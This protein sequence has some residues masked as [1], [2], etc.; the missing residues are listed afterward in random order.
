MHDFTL[1]RICCKKR[2]ETCHS[3]NI[4]IIVK[5]IRTDLLRKACWITILPFLKTKYLQIKRTPYYFSNSIKRSFFFFRHGRS[6][7][8]VHNSYG[9]FF[10]GISG[11]KFR[12]PKN[13]QKSL[14]NDKN[15]QIFSVKYGI[16][17]NLYGIQAKIDQFRWIV[18]VFQWFLPI[19]WL[20]EFW[21]R[22]SVKKNSVRIMTIWARSSVPIFFAQ[23]SNQ[24][25]H[26]KIKPS[27]SLDRGDRRTFGFVC[28]KFP[29]GYFD[30][31]F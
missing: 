16:R 13:W 31:R 7:P 17:S 22:N 11:P 10:Y 12:K 25:I 26:R 5:T 18:V 9:I 8:N 27:L 4:Q 6:R 29:L 28:T 15:D 20:T 1:R 23:G 24:N 21:T 2:N 3:F 19:F 14:K 30:A